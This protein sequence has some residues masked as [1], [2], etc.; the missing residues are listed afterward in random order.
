MSEKK[1][2]SFGKPQK[3]NNAKEFTQEDVDAWVNAGIEKTQQ[4][5]AKK[6][7][8]RF[9]IDAPQDLHQKV[10]IYCASNN[11]SVKDLI[12]KLLSEKLRDY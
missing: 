12:L 1:K 6:K 7:I 11:I 3:R 9:V 2:I 10:K 5:V 8:K 4:P